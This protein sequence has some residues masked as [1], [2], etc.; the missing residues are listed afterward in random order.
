MEGTRAAVEDIQWTEEGSL[1][2]V[3]TLPVDSVVNEWD[4][5]SFVA[6]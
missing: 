6:A 2:V 5:A 1:V 4:R 3:G